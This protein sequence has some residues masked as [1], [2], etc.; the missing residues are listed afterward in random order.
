MVGSVHQGTVA[1]AGTGVVIALS[2]TSMR[3]ASHQGLDIPV[4]LRMEMCCVWVSVAA[5]SR[6]VSRSCC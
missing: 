6:A 2:K 1:V 5:R 3:Q 4:S